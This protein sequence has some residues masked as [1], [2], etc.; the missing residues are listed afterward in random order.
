MCA[1]T[2]ESGPVYKIAAGS[3][4]PHGN[5]CS[6]LASGVWKAVCVD[7]ELCK[8]NADKRAARA[9]KHPLM[10]TRSCRA[11]AYT[12]IYHRLSTSYENDRHW[13]AEIMHTA[14]HLALSAG[15]AEDASLRTLREQSCGL[16][17]YF[18][19]LGM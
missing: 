18:A 17:G 4:P 15:L 6:F 2:R 11:L 1:T 5:A 8:N 9:C 7:S 13:S 14:L 3:V 19:G 16:E 10:K 12:L